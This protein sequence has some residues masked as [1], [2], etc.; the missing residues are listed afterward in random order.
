MLSSPDPWIGIEGT[1]GIQYLG[2][3]QR[4]LS[5]PAF[6]ER[7][8]AANSAGTGAWAGRSPD[9]CLDEHERLPSSPKI[10]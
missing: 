1:K 4:A 8:E 3:R 10:L 6:L 5:R 7:I 2:Q 9:R